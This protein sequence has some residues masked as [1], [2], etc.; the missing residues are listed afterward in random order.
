MSLEFEFIFIGN[1]GPETALI[2]DRMSGLPNC[3]F[4]K[5]ITLLELAMAME[6]SDVF[7]F[8]S[9]AEGGARVV[10]EAM[11][12]GMPIITTH[13]SGSPINHL[14][15]GIIVKPNDSFTILEWLVEL[16][17]N[18]SL[19]GKLGS[20]SRKKIESMIVKD[21]YLETIRGVCNL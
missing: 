15:E 12:M 9:R 20:Q 4:V 11:C 7:L 5:W 13:N 16:S 6:N 1:W 14:E 19:F 8:P 21:T 3:K 10:T 17:N 18:D 2:Q